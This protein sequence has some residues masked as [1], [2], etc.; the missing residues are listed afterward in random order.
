MFT[1]GAIAAAAG[2]GAALG[3]AGSALPAAWAVTVAA[4]LAVMGALREAGVLR[5]PLPALRRQVPEPW[6]REKPLAFWSAGYGVILGSGFGTFQPVATFW[7]VCA[8]SVALGR[9]AIAALCLAPFGLGRALMIAFPGDDALRRLAGAHRMLRPVNAAAL[10]AAALLLVPSIVSGAPGALPTG[11]RDPSVSKHVIAYTAAKDGASKVV[12]LA[13]DA[14]PVVFEGGRLPALNGDVLAYVD[15]AGIRIVLWR[16]GVEVGRVTGRVDKPALSGPRLAYVETIGARKRLLLRNL[17]TNV[18]RVIARAGPAVDLG[19]PALL[20]QLIA[21]HESGGDRNH[22]FV[23][24]LTGGPVRVVASG[25]RSRL[26][27]NPVLTPG[28]IA[29]VESRAEHSSLLIRRLPNGVVRHVASTSGPVF[30]FWNTAIE[31][32]RVWVTRWALGSNRSRVLAY[33][34]AR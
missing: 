23:R 16:T 14:P 34:W 32:G 25:S 31:P 12:V 11:Q 4:M 13:K 18:V 1:L 9:P 26:Q 19:R 20:E 28:Y 22:V 6:R 7:V 15:D 21:W 10:A 5:L 24:S 3:A 27:A 8:G 33:R 30:H 2:L 17:D 29:W